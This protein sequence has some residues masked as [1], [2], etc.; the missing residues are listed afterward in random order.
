MAMTAASR[1][2]IDTNILVYANLAQS[3]FH[4]QAVARLREL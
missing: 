2:F 3:P 1:I 4:N